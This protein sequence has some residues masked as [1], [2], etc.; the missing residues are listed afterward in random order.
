MLSV[1]FIYTN[2][3]L[4]AQWTLS[5][6]LSLATTQQSTYRLAIFWFQARI[7][8][9]IVEQEN[10]K[11]FDKPCNKYYP[12]A[13]QWHLYA[14]DSNILFYQYVLKIHIAYTFF[15]IFFQC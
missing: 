8:S 3:I 4:K 5:C 14:V 13:S 7:P 15:P 6:L 10:D 11:Q 2:A 12:F 9:S 1:S